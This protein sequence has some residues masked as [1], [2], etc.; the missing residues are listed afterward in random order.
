MRSHKVH[1]VG[2]KSG[3]NI[4]TVTAPLLLI[5]RY[6]NLNVVAQVKTIQQSDRHTT[7]STQ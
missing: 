5:I 7:Y 3:S 4:L 6:R 2:G 1:T